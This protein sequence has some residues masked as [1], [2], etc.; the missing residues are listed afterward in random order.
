MR[1]AAAA[2]D[3]RDV[4]DVG[5]AGQARSGP[6][7][8]VGDDLSSRFQ[9]D[10]VAE[11]V[12]STVVLKKAH[13]AVGA[14]V[15]EWAGEVDAQGKGVVGLGIWRRWQWRR[16]SRSMERGVGEEKKDQNREACIPAEHGCSD[17]AIDRSREIL[18]KRLAG[19]RKSSGRSAHNT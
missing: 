15:T 7:E 10:G 16:G 2:I 18:G 1:P 3:D 5:I 13:P 4:G 8:R 12:E 19:G 9:A 14:A 11:A 17:W 6:D